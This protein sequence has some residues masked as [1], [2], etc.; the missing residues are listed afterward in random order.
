MLATALQ[1]AWGISERKAFD[2]TVDASE[3]LRLRNATIDG[4]TSTLRK[5]R[6]SGAAPPDETAA[7]M[8]L[9]LRCESLEAAIRLFR[10]LLILGET[11]GAKAVADVV[12]QLLSS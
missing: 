12:R 4:R 7:L 2:L 6:K 10:S 5:K 11:K 9:A 3:D 1:A 8:M